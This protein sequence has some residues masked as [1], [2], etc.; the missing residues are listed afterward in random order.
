V[1]W[2][3]SKFCIF[4]SGGKIDLATGPMLNGLAHE[5][6]RRL[7]RCPSCLPGFLVTMELVSYVVRLERFFVLKG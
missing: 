6:E 1:I 2:L 5:V 3:V 4:L 7:S